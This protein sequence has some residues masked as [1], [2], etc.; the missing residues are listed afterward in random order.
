MFNTV[1]QEKQKRANLRVELNEMKNK[2]QRK[3]D[4][5]KKIDNIAFAK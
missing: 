2:V 4:I 5:K 3:V 1:K